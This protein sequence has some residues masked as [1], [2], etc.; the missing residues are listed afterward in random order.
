M[1]P[2]III[3][4][5][6]HGVVIADILYKAEHQI[7]GFLDDALT[8]GTD[9]LDSKV[10]GK[11]EDCKNHLECLFIIGIGNNQVRKKISQDYALKYGTAIHPSAVTG[12]HVLIDVGTVVMAGSVINSRTSIGKHSIINT[13]ACVEHD[14]IISDF[15]HVSPCVALGGSVSIGEGSHL[16]IGSCV[17]NGVSICSNVV[18]GAGAVVVKDIRTSGVYVGIPARA[19]E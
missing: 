16:G 19:R 3:G 9:V 14:N 1:K 17:R 11:I 6:G 5:G 18:V 13:G 4:A 8:I 12:G 2:Y 7:K 15:V 10:I